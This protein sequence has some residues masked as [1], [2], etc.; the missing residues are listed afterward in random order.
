MQLDEMGERRIIEEVLGP[1]YGGKWFGDDCAYFP[2]AMKAGD[3]I[4]GTTDPCPEPMAAMLGYDDPYYRGWLLAT[5]N[6]SDLGAGGAEPLG[7]LTSLVLPNNFEVGQLLR[8]LDG[9]DDCCKECGTEVRGGNIKEGSRVDLSATA[10]GLLPGGRGLTRGGASVGDTIVAIG[11]LGLFWTGVLAVQHSLTLSDEEREAAL[12][13][14][15]TP[16][17]KVDI[18]RA[19]AE[20]RALTAC[21][22]NSD[23]VYASLLQIGAASH[24]S[25]NVKADHL[26]YKAVVWRVSRALRV[27]PVR[28]TLGWG[29]W[30]LIGCTR[31]L[32]RVEAICRV[33][34]VEVQALGTVERGVGVN[35]EY[36]GKKGPMAHIDSER[37]TSESWFTAGIQSYIS[38]LLDAPLWHDE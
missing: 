21:M 38:Q 18:G 19:L 3:L 30:Q 23:G 26:Q 22:D 24:V 10:I 32:A 33:H 8:L 20:A 4:V 25:M 37:F 14:V 7:L 15:L 28:L 1:R 31:D 16:L 12:R 13:N 35:L 11:D 5:I 34:G 6:L 2:A 36:D 29:D 27:D 9:I 17:P